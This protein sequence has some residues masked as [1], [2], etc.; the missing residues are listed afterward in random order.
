VQEARAEWKQIK[1]LNNIIFYSLH[2]TEDRE[3]ARARDLSTIRK[4]KKTVGKKIGNSKKCAN[5]FF[6]RSN[7]ID[8]KLMVAICKR[9]LVT[10]Y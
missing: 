10:F 6:E 5:N 8:Y 9:L 1:T 3:R 7:E 2:S 4:I